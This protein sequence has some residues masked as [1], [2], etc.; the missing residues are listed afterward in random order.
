[1]TCYDIF[2]AEPGRES[3]D[4]TDNIDLFLNSAVERI[5]HLI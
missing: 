4:E 2:S 3:F 1:M 5:A